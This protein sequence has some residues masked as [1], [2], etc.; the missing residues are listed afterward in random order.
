MSALIHSPPPLATRDILR[1]LVTLLCG[2]TGTAKGNSAMAYPSPVPA[3]QCQPKSLPRTCVPEEPI[4]QGERVSMECLCPAVVSP[5]CQQPQQQ[6]GRGGLT[7]IPSPDLKQL[8]LAE[9]RDRRLSLAD[10]LD[11]LVGRC[12]DGVGSGR[13]QAFRKDHHAHVWGI[14]VTKKDPCCCQSLRLNGLLILPVE[15]FSVRP[16]PGIKKGKKQTNVSRVPRSL[17]S[18]ELQRLNRPG[19]LGIYRSQAPISIPSRPF[20]GYVY[21]LLKKRQSRLIPGPCPWAA[22]SVP[23]KASRAVYVKTPVVLPESKYI[24]WKIHQPE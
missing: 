7:W 14:G 16:H 23:G 17:C 5:P 10:G 13:G 24:G 8:L 4:L 21:S 15:L 1:R 19:S 9:D 3:C 2:A 6:G 18:K 20:R 11:A 22:E 12:A